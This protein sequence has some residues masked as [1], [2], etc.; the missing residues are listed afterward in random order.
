[1]SW[2][3]G[4]GCSGALVLGWVGWRL[5]ADARVE[6]MLGSRP[7]PR[8]PVLVRI[9]SRVPLEGA[10]ARAR[11]RGVEAVEALLGAKVVLAACGVLAGL[12]AGGLR[13]PILAVA[14]AA[15]G[16]VAPDV[17]AARAAE[18]RRRRAAATVPDLVDLV[19]LGVT[20]G[21]SPHA[22]LERAV[23]AAPLAVRGGLV[24][25]R[26]RV[27]LGETWPA[28]LREVADRWSDRD[29]RRLAS[30]LE[31]GTRL[32][33]PVLG[34]L[35]DFAGDVRAR[36]LARR[37]E[38]ARR[39]PVLMLFPLVLCILPAFVVA[40]IVPAVLVATRGIG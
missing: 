11:R 3:L 21:L 20:A 22:A 9:G 28:T 2:L 32:G 13:A 18:A 25:A 23:G 15:G 10:R 5:R 27:R 31:R 35:L 38:R 39:A 37:E 16:Y 19:A 36:D 30:I 34:S 17:L 7:D 14:L 12:S 6:G 8:V 24:R 40:A 33:A 26:D 4:L 29:L 1:M